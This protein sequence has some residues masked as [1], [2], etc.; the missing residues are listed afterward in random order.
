MRRFITSVAVLLLGSAGCTPSCTQVCDKV[1]ACENAGT[2]RMSEGECEESC[3]D[4]RD[5]YDRWTDP[6]KVHAFEDELTCL[7]DSECA[8]IEDGVCY[9]EEV[10]AF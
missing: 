10:W 3:A 5:L 2:E 9:D 1:L 4:Q 8:D 6:D 7:Y